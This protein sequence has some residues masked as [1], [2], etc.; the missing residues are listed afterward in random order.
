MTTASSPGNNASSSSLPDAVVIPQMPQNLNISPNLVQQTKLDLNACS[1]HPENST[2]PGTIKQEFSTASGSCFIK[3][4]CPD[5]TVTTPSVSLSC[6]V[7][8][9]TSFGLAEEPKVEMD[10]QATEPVA[11]ILKLQQEPRVSSPPAL[12]VRRWQLKV[13]ENEVHCY[14][15]RP[16]PYQEQRQRGRDSAR[17]RMQRLRQSRRGEGRRPIAGRTTPIDEAA[18]LRMRREYWRV[19]KQEQRAKKAAEVRL[20][21]QA[22]AGWEMQGTDEAELKSVGCLPKTVAHSAGL[23]LPPSPG[24][25]ENLLG[26]PATV[27]KQEPQNDSALLHTG[28]VTDRQRDGAASSCKHLEIN[29]TKGVCSTNYATFAEPPENVSLETQVGRA[30]ELPSCTLAKGPVV[31]LESQQ[32]APA[33]SPEG[34][35]VRRWKLTIQESDEER[36]APRQNRMCELRPAAP[37]KVPRTMTK[38]QLDEATLQQRREYWRLKKQEQ[39]A[40]TSARK[41]E[42]RRQGEAEGQRWQQLREMQ[43]EDEGQQ[44]TFCE[45]SNIVAQKSLREEEAG[46]HVKAELCEDDVIPLQLRAETPDPGVGTEGPEPFSEDDVPD[47]EAGWRTRF[48]MDYDPQ[49][50]LLVCMVCGVVQHQQSLESVRSHISESHPHSLSLSAQDKHSILEAWDEQVS[51]RE[52]FFSSQLQQGGS[53]RESPVAEIEVFV[54]SDEQSV[55]KKRSSTKVKRK[56][57]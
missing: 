8:T 17:R 54:D 2:L 55:C 51:L 20:A 30:E 11:V 31:I 7:Q 40:K 28:T 33:S 4:V 57:T 49:T 22:E 42:M 3:E 56:R 16:D 37:H 14:P 41:R 53:G 36:G 18:R 46:R 12:Q 44:F 27:E 39:R 35:R 34:P 13:Q 48:L 43:G 47:S 9:N 24:P 1:A 26:L 45:E 21:R 50:A 10:S 5:L 15:L 29:E 19:K 25:P 23:T 52:R 38:K 32:D 6:A